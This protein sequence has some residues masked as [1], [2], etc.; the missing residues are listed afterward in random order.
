VQC[1]ADN[2]NAMCQ[3]VVDE[4]FGAIGYDRVM[5]YK[6]HEDMHGEVGLRA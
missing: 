2:T 5:I 4:V 3:L 6:F 1:T